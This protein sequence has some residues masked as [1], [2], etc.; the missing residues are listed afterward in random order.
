MLYLSEIGPAICYKGRS[1]K[2]K[3][4]TNSKDTT[5]LVIWLQYCL[6]KGQQVA[7]YL[8]KQCALCQ[9]FQLKLFKNVG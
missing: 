3:L 1:N 9:R 5:M 6:V 8:I 7:L 4:E 2:S